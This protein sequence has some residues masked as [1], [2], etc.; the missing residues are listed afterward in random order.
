MSFNVDSYLAALK[1]ARRK[2]RAM[3]ASL[4]V[5]S[6]FVSGNVF[7][8]LRGTGVAMAD[9]DPV[10]ETVSSEETEETSE[11]TET[12][13]T[14]VILETEETTETTVGS[15]ILEEVPEETEDL[16]EETGETDVF[17]NP[18]KTSETEE[19]LVY[20]KAP[21]SEFKEYRATTKNG[22]TVSVLAETG[23]FPDGTSMTA[24]YISEGP[25]IAQLSEEMDLDEKKI[26]E[27]IPVDISFYDEQGNVIEPLEGYM[28]SVF[29]N[30]PDGLPLEGDDL[31]LIHI[32]KEGNTSEVDEVVLSDSKASFIAEEF[33]IYVLT[34]LGE[35]DKEYV[36]E[37]LEG[38]WQAPNHE[39]YIYNTYD[40]P[41]I[42]DSDDD[43]YLVYYTSDDSK[44][45]FTNDNGIVEVQSIES[46]FNQD[47]QL[48]RHLSR[49]VPKGE[50]KATIYQDAGNNQFESFFIEVR[51]YNK[52]VV[53]NF[54]D[55]NFIQYNNPDNAYIVNVGD[56]IELRGSSSDGNNYF[57]LVDGNGQYITSSQYLTIEGNSANGNGRTAVLNATDV[58]YN[59][60]IPIYNN[61]NYVGVAINAGYGN[62]DTRIVYFK[63]QERS[64]LDH[65]DIEIADGGEYKSTRVYIENG[66]L[67]KEVTTYQSAVYGV[68]SCEM[69]EASGDYVTFYKDAGRQ[70]DILPDVHGYAGDF[71]NGG[72][73]WKNP[74]KKPGETQYE[75][76]SKYALDQNGNQIHSS[77][78]KYMFADVDH[79]IFDVQLEL[80]P[81][82]KQVYVKNGDNWVLSSTADISSQSPEYIDSAVF[83]MD[84]R[85]VI[86]AFN[87][88]PY[89]N[90]LD[91]TIK[92]DLAMVQFEAQKILKN[93]T[94]AGDDYEF[95][96]F[97]RTYNDQTGTYDEQIVSTAKNDANGKV[98]FDSIILEKPGTYQYYIREIPGN[99]PN[100][101]YD[102]TTYDITII[103]GN[104]MS[105]EIQSDTF[106]YEFTNKVMFI[107]PETGGIGIVP[108]TI[109]GCFL[110]SAAVFIWVTRKRKR[111]GP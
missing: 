4:I 24:E 51:D 5:F 33:S 71:A 105:I 69:F 65:A 19:T 49:V 8:M 48:Y 44:W 94:L 59:P 1:E 53:I 104:D 108:Y 74:N 56:N 29:I 17:E 32:D 46:E 9:E 18:E 28:V 41:Y 70:Q 101:D 14:E 79:V 38:Y 11:T 12:N 97:T 95:E 37:W 23:A 15:E 99:D 67:K 106:N 90:G 35:R 111:D 10:F 96:L 78:K 27:A 83:E 66:V 34:S 91:F 43:M 73:Y 22:I 2:R 31:S 76:T 47:L 30:L 36:H 52:T 42:I 77:N 21:E 7:W 72:D 13:E 109:S 6:I 93:G 26:I 75:L 39:G 50:G 20:D 68:N 40:Y 87:K 62:S 60:Y 45:L 55:Y 57:Y 107:L 16:T 54:D 88:C 64:L 92:A 85:A 63:I 58:N 84:R 3:L 61:N 25:I 82:T 103:V 86:D 100:I 102:T 80:E 81:L 89:N 98:S 110:I